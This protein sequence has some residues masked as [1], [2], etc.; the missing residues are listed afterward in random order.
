MNENKERLTGDRPDRWTVPVEGTLPLW[1]QCAAHIQSLIER[2]ELAPGEQLPCHTELAAATGVGAST[3][4]KALSWLTSEGVLV[5][6]RQRGTF[7][8]EI[9]RAA[10]GGWIAVITRAM[11]DP[12]MSRFDFQAARA[13]VDTLADAGMSFR[14]YHNQYIP[15]G[16]H[17]DRQ[18][19]DPR[20]CEDA[21]A[22]RVRGVIVIG[23][24]PVNHPEFRE[25]LK[26]SQVPL[27]ET[28][29]RS[30]ETPFVVEFDR[31]AFMK[32]AVALAA[33]RGR[34]RLGLIETPG[35]ILH[36][37]DPLLGTFIQA[38]ASAG[39]EVVTNWVRQ[40]EWPPGTVKGVEI[41][42][43][44]R[45][46]P[47]PTPD[48]L[49]I[50]DE[51]VALGVAQAALAANVAVPGELWLTT[52]VTIGADIAYPV[53]MA[54]FGFSADQLMRQSWTMLQARMNGEVVRQR[55]VRIQPQSF[56]ILPGYIE[57]LSDPIRNFKL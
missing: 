45:T 1:R 14:F 30:E 51:Y 13:V 53:P 54:T 46:Q 6:H 41:F 21:E 31:C 47:G 35:Y 44:L 19:V 38:T 33:Q 57:N 48:A 55:L 9:S 15:G 12:Q 3:L 52:S 8:A 26:N 40:I 24:V 10:A 50:T 34:R 20:L 16:P 36:G 11:F 28:S 22:G 2:G 25:L 37:R 29:G 7:V 56:D 5:R 39:L 18:D 42:N 49:I 27:V 43:A 32:Q 23:T 4:Q 17:A